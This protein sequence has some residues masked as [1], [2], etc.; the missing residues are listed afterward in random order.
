MAKYIDLQ[1]VSELADNNGYVRYEDILCIPAADV[2]SRGAYEQVA[3]ER[4]IAIE[5]LREIGKSLGEKMD[6][7]RRKNNNE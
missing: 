5:Q 2:V 1:L 7:I 3:W 6:D 4:S